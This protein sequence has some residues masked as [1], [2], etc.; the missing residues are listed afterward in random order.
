MTE[1]TV[2]VLVRPSL[3]GRVWITEVDLDAGGDRE[4][5]VAR[6]LLALVPGDGRGQLPRQGGDGRLHGRLDLDGPLAV[7]EV[8]QEQVASRA[9]DEGADGAATSCSH[10]EVSLPV[11]RDR[12]ILDLGWSLRDHDHVLDAAPRLD[13][14]LRLALGAAAA[15]EAGQLSTQLFSPLDEEGLRDGLVA[16]VHGRDRSDAS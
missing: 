9:L 12:S 13:P 15:K 4:L 14:T 2:G 16:R 10:H 1:Q 8:E 3:P 6:H 5:S 7:G 11:A